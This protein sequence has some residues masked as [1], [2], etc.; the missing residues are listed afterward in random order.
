[1]VTIN[2]QPT[3]A[4]NAAY[5]PLMYE[6][7]INELATRVSPVLECVIYA[8]SVEQTRIKLTAINTAA[9]STPGT[10]DYRF[11][12]DA[13]EIIQDYFTDN[14]TP[15]PFAPGAYVAAGF[16]PVLRVG[17]FAWKD[18]GSG[19]L[20]RTGS[21]VNSS[22]VFVI[23]AYRFAQ[24]S[25]S[26][27]DYT[28]ASNRKWLSYLPDKLSVCRTDN[29]YLSIFVNTAQVGIAIEVYNGA[30]LQSSG[31]IY[32]GASPAASTL[33]C[34]GAGPANIADT[35]TTWL[36][37]PAVISATS[38]H[39]TATAVRIVGS[40]L[41]PFSTSFR[42]NLTDT[43]CTRQFLFLNPFGVYETFSVGE[44]SI[45]AYDV[46]G[47]TSTSPRLLP[48]EAGY[49]MSRESNYFEKRAVNQFL[50]QL[51]ESRDAHRDHYRGFLNSPD[52]YLI[53]GSTFV[54]VRISTGS[55]NLRR[56][57]ELT[58]SA[59]W[60]NFDVSQKT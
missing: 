8:N 36:A 29:A 39:Y 33:L 19:L 12:F 10:I 58:V 16:L 32:F 45:I 46:D 28:Q 52:V 59:T 37:S 1:M 21:I 14:V 17:F 35:L 30:T 43:C 51:P 25:P 22:N 9:G 42:F 57:F 40:V 55:F 3:L 48:S 27:T 11:Q 53:D 54:P 44:E 15:L 41:T 60:S 4:L 26:L 7:T 5:L 13:Q 24:Q 31:V 47:E 23:N 38:T 6:C 20:V 2:S 49:L 18:N 56:N 50:F 34:V